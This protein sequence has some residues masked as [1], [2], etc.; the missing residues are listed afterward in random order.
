MASGSPNLRS[1]A[2]GKYTV[3]L[4]RKAAGVHHLLVID[5]L[6]CPGDPSNVSVGCVGR[7]MEASARSR[8]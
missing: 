8:L 2:D 5:Q 4:K 3:M 7:A 6:G 1:N